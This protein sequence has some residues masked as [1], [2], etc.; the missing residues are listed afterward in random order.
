MK[1]PCA[2]AQVMQR[3]PGWMLR[4]ESEKMELRP[5][6]ERRLDLELMGRGFSATF[7]DSDEEK[8]QRRVGALYPPDLHFSYGVCARLRP[9]MP[10]LWAVGPTQRAVWACSRS[11]RPSC[12]SHPSA[13]AAVCRS[14][15]VLA[16]LG[17]RYARRP[18][19]EVLLADRF[20]QDLMLHAPVLETT[21]MVVLA[22]DLDIDH[23]RE[24]APLPP[25]PFSLFLVAVFRS[26]RSAA[27]GCQPTFCPAGRASACL[28]LCGA[29][30]KCARVP[31]A[32]RTFAASRAKNRKQV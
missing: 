17:P 11:P 2:P 31:G 6:E 28:A 24:C 25:L 18:P 15:N 16:M 20:Y 13:R 23:L 27:A 5:G 8:W 30:M 3:K 32:R 29:D 12:P 1:L 22:E 7:P 10:G 9:L 4:P 19:A 14:E 21:V 26:S